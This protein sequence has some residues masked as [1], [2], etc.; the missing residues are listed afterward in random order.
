MAKAKSQSKSQHTVVLI[1]S[2]NYDVINVELLVERV[3]FRLTHV[4]DTRAKL[5]VFMKQL[6]KDIMHPQ[7]VIISD[8]FATGYDDGRKIADHIR[9]YAADTKILA[10]TLEREC[11]PWADDFAV[12]AGLDNDHTLLLGLG[13]LMG[14]DLS[15]HRGEVDVS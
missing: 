13:K 3:G 12:K 1:E 15:E 7:V 10:Y 11:P 6:R 5:K 9:K 14:V 8:Y 2:D 4:V